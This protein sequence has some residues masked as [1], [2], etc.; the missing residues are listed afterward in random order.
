M[1]DKFPRFE[2]RGSGMDTSADQERERRAAAATGVITP[3]AELTWPYRRRDSRSAIRATA[4]TASRRPA[5]TRASRSGTPRQERLTR[6]IELDNGARDLACPV[7]LARLTGHSRRPD[8][9]VGLG[10]RREDRHLQAQRGRGLVDHL[11]R[12]R[13]PLR[14]LEPRLESGLVGHCRLPA[15]PFRC[16]TPTRTP[17]RPLPTPSSPHGPLLAS[18][19]ADKT[20]KLWNLD[21]LDRIRTYRGHKDF[22]T[23]LA[24]AP[25]GNMLASAS[26]DGIIRLWSTSLEPPPA[27]PLWPPRTR[28][29]THLL[30]RRQH[31]RLG[32]RR[33]PAAHLG[34]RPRPHIAHDHGHSGAV[35][36]VSILAG[37]ER[38]G[39]GGRRRRRAHLG[40]PDAARGH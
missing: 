33:R 16:S 34:Y 24:F 35:N 26:L 10:E 19:G 9:A 14:R 32:R 4:P 20:V 22:V 38:I 5:R 15:R 21:T 7:R 39:F 28:R 30:A 1:Q 13:R 6:T 40:E 29:R 3:V 12:P 8:R 36:A 27:P 2:S 17:R 25:D 37:R 31:H 23:A 11:H 18:G